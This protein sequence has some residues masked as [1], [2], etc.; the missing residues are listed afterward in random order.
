MPGAPIDVVMSVRLFSDLEPAELG[1]LADAMYERV[2]RAGETATT[3]GDPGD[4][5]FVVVSGE[6]EITV[7]GRPVGRI[8]PGDHFGEIAL[9]MGAGRAA[10]IT[11]VSDLRCY[12]LAPSSFR[13]IVEGSPALAFKLM[14]SMTQTLP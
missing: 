14:Q 8:G 9:L 1:L 10:T 7:Q 13:S 2:F 12:G 5:F 3:E 6:A 11:A 4:G